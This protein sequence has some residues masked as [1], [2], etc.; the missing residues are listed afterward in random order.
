MSG[1]G[2]VIAGAV[3][4]QIVGKLG[5]YAA[6]E[7]TLQWR[8]REDML[9]LGEKMKDLEAVLVDADDKSHRGGE[10]GR[11]FQRWLT[12]FK[13]VAYNVEDVLDELEANELIKKS[14]S[15]VNLWFSR[16][17]QLV[18]RI[19]MPHKM[20]NAMKKIGKIKKEG[21]TELNLVPL[22]SRAEGSR[23]NETLAA[24]WN[25]DGVKTGIVGRETEKDK[26]ISLLLTSEEA[27]QDI[28]IIPIVGLGG[29]G[30]T[31]LAES[32]LADTRVSVFDV[33]IWVNVSK[34]F[35]LHKIGGAILKRMMNGTINPDNCD[36][37]QVL[38]K[39]LATRRYL[40]VLDDLWE[41]DG[42]KLE[43]L[44][45]MLQH[46]LKG[47]RIIVTTRNRSVVQQLRT[48]F[49]SN[50]RKICPVPESETIEL[51]V[52]EPVEC[53][54]LMKQ[55]AFGPDDDHN[56]LEEIGK[57]IAGKC[58][59]LPLVA[60]ALGH[61]MSEL[62]TVEAWEHIRD[63]KV[64]LGLRDQK[65]TLERLMPSYYHMKPEFKLCFTYLATFPKG[66]VMDNNHI[67]QQW[68]AL[69]YINSRHEGQRCI[70]HLLGMSF[71]RIPG[72]ASVST[73]RHR[74][75]CMAFHFYHYFFFFTLLID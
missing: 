61:V 27:N 69:G 51:G 2:A 3:A 55:R 30:K 12:K 22:E 73:Y 19:T 66:L 70:N 4:K 48:G 20:K 65:E 17:N 53:W 16:N 60:N 46:G 71:L 18:Q 64:D 50:Q 26:I 8:Y 33:S 45:R 47:S 13:R 14:Q 56:G 23:N 9:E 7:V 49:L 72:S 5:D 37:Q 59:G 57:Q 24:N 11:V 52:L 15:K 74:F 35:D 10:A 31:T 54:E 62:R 58:G 75:S 38:K 68:N 29:I 34:Q 21:S 32:V 39:E 36:L 6:S 41:E 43:S 67:I 40:I 28:S 63:T 25:T 42:D 44:K 1:L